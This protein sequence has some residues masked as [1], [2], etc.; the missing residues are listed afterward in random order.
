M[1]CRRLRDQ[2]I[3]V[4][5]RHFCLLLFYPS[6]YGAAPSLCWY[7]M[8]TPSVIILSLS[9]PLDQ[10]TSSSSQLT[11]NNSLIKIC[12]AVAGIRDMWTRIMENLCCQGNKN[13]IV[14]ID[15][16]P[17]PTISVNKGSSYQNI[18]PSINWAQD[19]QT[20]WFRW[21]TLTWLILNFQTS[22]FPFLLFQGLQFTAY[23][24]KLFQY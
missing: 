1:R 18:A 14:N 23:S 2:H 6:F 4:V 20:T 13:H 9:C 11:E 16:F 15:T 8:D 22:G 24:G 21:L 5:Q 7:L 3:R 10:S 19:T 17:L 12:L